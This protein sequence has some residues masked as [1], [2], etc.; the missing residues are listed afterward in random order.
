VLPG[1]LRRQSF[2]RERTAPFTLF[3]AMA[4]HYRI[5]RRMKLRFALTTASAGYDPQDSRWLFAVVPSTCPCI[6]R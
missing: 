4:S 3:A 6:P 1:E 2:N 5:H